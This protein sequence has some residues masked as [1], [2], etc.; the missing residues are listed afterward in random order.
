MGCWP[1][2]SQFLFQFLASQSVVVE[3]LSVLRFYA[4]LIGKQLLA[5]TYNIQKEFLFLFNSF[6][7]K[8]SCYNNR[9]SGISNNFITAATK[10]LGQRTSYMNG[11]LPGRL[12]ICG[13]IPGMDKGVR[14]SIEISNRPW[15][16][17][18]LLFN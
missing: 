6:Y 12:K 14:H 3:D 1:V 15:F 11:L 10:E 4:V 5:D 17:I 18:S 8:E 7:H 2:I 16:L 9:V 13:S